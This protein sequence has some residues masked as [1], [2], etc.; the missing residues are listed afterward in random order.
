MLP[1]SSYTF[2]RAWSGQLHR[3]HFAVTDDQVGCCES[4]VHLYLGATGYLSFNIGSILEVLIAKIILSIADCFA[5]CCPGEE[6][7]SVML[8]Y[9]PL[10]ALPNRL[11]APIH[12]EFS[13]SL[14]IVDI[15][16]EFCK[17]EADVKAVIAWLGSPYM[18]K[19]H[20]LHLWIDSDFLPFMRDFDRSQGCFQKVFV[21][22]NHLS[23]ENF[24]N[25]AWISREGVNGAID[26]LS[27]NLKD[28]LQDE[29]CL[30]S[31]KI[32]LEEGS[33]NF[34]LRVF[35]HDLTEAQGKIIGAS[36]E[37]ANKDN[38]QLTLIQPSASALSAI[39]VA[40]KMKFLSIDVTGI[41]IR[42]LGSLM[43]F[44][45]LDRVTIRGFAA[46]MKDFSLKGLKKLNKPQ[47]L[48]LDFEKNP[49]PIHAHS[50]SVL[51]LENLISLT[52]NT[53]P[54]D[55]EV[56]ILHNC[57]PRAHIHYRC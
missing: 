47:A 35:I 46:S 33:Q 19:R 50:L 14:H 55:Q 40:V 45:H 1:V 6:D 49:F 48:Y 43:N 8:A 30:E 57:F 20:L 54:T 12:R 4:F 21:A 41:D 22:F 3:E 44:H 56:D 26:E 32:L 2:E 39:P 16:L 29:E 36:L 9:R 10:Q 53:P 13:L 42:T 52:L 11:W 27:I 15:N 25:V 31:L 17:S 34:S 38:L 18:P 7:A 28:L 5:W 51:H 23:K 24:R 37:K